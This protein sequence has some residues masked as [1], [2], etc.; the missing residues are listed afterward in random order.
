MNITLNYP[1][2][3]FSKE[4]EQYILEGNTLEDRHT[5]KDITL[6]KLKSLKRDFNFWNKEVINFLKVRFNSV[7]PNEYLNDFIDVDRFDLEPL[8]EVLKESDENILHFKLKNFKESCQKKIDVLILLQRNLKFIENTFPEYEDAKTNKIMNKIFISH[9]SLDSKYVEKIID[10]LET[11]GVPSNKIFCS[12][13]EGYGIK[14]GK[15]FLEQLRN[16]LSENVLVIFILSNNFYSS[17]ISLCEMGATWIKTNDHIPMLIPPFDYSDMKGVIPTSHGMKIDEKEG[18]NSFKE[19][20]EKYLNIFPI[21]TSIWERK[22]DNHLKE[23]KHL[24]TSSNVSSD[25]FSETK[26]FI[27]EDD[28]YYANSNIIIKKNS[29]IEWPTDF[30]M[31]LYY[32]EKQKTAVENLKL[33]NPMDIDKKHFEL[34]RNKARIEWKEDYE[35]QL[36][37]EQRQIESLRRLNQM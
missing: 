28:D 27:S 4:L 26:S 36:D 35:M 24:I 16:E 11:I 18:Y 9:S 14:L 33:H 34:I 3:E 1:R 20:I 31:Q 22:R 6:V 5:N 21:N 25:T 12:S 23:I 19:L 2:A 37:F 7:L 30:E 13:F 10:L 32:I 17:V 15:D 8:A 29:E